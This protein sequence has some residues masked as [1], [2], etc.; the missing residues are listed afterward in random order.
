MARVVAV[1][2]RHGT[3]RSLEE[4]RAAALDAVIAG[5]RAGIGGG[6]VYAAIPVITPFPYV[7][8]HVVYAKRVCVLSL[9]FVGFTAAV[10]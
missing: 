6:A 2:T 4:P 1:P 8:A 7:S 5:S 3:V 9:Y 10:A